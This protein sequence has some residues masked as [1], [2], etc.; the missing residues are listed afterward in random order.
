ML[1]GC[2]AD[3]TTLSTT[4][5]SERKVFKSTVLH[6]KYSHPV[7]LRTGSAVLWEVPTCWGLCRDCSGPGCLVL[8]WQRRTRTLVELAQTQTA[9][10]QTEDSGLRCLLSQAS[11][12]PLLESEQ[13]QKQFAFFKATKTESLLSCIRLKLYWSAILIGYLSASDN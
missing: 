1:A 9:A 7:C 11:P 4:S 12:L 10:L 13:R 3:G 8:W 6:S 5:R 2:T